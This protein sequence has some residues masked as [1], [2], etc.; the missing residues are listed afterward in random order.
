MTVAG[1]RSTARRRTRGTSSAP[2]TRPGVAA[3]SH[4]GPPAAP[5]PQLIADLLTECHLDPNLLAAADDPDWDQAVATSTDTVAAMLGQSPAIPAVGFPGQQPA[6]FT[7]PVLSP[8]PTGDQA[9]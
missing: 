9:L 1:L 7:G 3:C 2:S 5:A 6:A 8:V 4:P